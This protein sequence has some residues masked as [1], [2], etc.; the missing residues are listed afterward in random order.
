MPYRRTRSLSSG[1]REEREKQ[2]NTRRPIESGIVALGQ[3]VR[4]HYTTAEHSCCSVNQR[5]A[6]LY[7]GYLATKNCIKVVILSV[8]P[9]RR[10]TKNLSLLI[11][12]AKGVV[13]W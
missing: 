8:D 1:R 5:A 10:L 3:R 13:L 9:R 12:Q 6:Q 7:A 11:A 2:Q 4:N